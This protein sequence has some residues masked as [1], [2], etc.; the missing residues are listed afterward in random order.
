MTKPSPEFER[1]DNL[2]AGKASRVKRPVRAKE[3]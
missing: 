2:D 3:R 1:F